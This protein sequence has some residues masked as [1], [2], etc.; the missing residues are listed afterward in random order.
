M[1][2][3]L[4][5]AGL[6]HAVADVGQ[7]VRVVV[8]CSQG[9]VPREVGADMLVWATG[10]S[11]TI[12]GGALEFEAA[13]AAR[14][15]LGLAGAWRRQHSK[16]SL[17]PD[18]G[19]CCGGVVELL[20]ERISSFELAAIEGAAPTFTRPKADG[21]SPAPAP[22]QAARLRQA[23]RTGAD[24]LGVKFRDGWISEGFA[25]PRVPLWLYGAGHVGRAIV[26]VLGGLDYDICWIDTARERFPD[27][28]PARVSWKAAT[29]PASLVQDAPDNA[30]HFVL[31]YSH[32][33]DLE[34]CHQVLS[35]PFTHLGLIGSASKKARFLKRLR[36]LGHTSSTLSRLECPIGDR[37]LG[38]SPGA[39]AIGLAYSLLS[40]NTVALN[41]EAI[42]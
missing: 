29:N 33:H 12:G 2:R 37:S 18:L 15:M 6:R 19:Q 42:A 1:S 13:Q 40:R 4:D 30:L 38:K 3:G 41:N 11:G 34:I 26:D 14:E 36:E 31:T 7:V 21:I 39:V 16:I 5:I 28:I 23:E 17:G 32:A 24:T 25:A 8:V 35:R 10:Q 27:V 20:F 22:L 9:S